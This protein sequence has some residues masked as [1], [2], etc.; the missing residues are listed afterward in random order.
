MLKRNQTTIT[1]YIE[2]GIIMLFSLY[3]ILPSANNSINFMLMLMFVAVYIAYIFFKNFESAKVILM[4]VA[5]IA[6]LALMK[7]LL[8]DT[9][10]ITGNVKI[11]Q[12]FSMLHQYIFMFIP[13]FLFWRVKNTANY[14]QKKFILLFVSAIIAYV[15]FQTMQ[16]VTINPNAMRNWA[17]FEE[18]AKENVANYYFVYAIPIIIVAITTVFRKLNII[19]KILAI[20]A[21]LILMNFLLKA[22]YTLALLIVVIGIILQLFFSIKNV[23][24]KMLFVF[25]TVL[26]IFFL[27]SLLLFISEN[28][29]SEQVSLRL[30]E[31]Y[32][33]LSSGDASGYNL[34]GR[35]ILYEK[36]IIAFFRSPIWGN[37]YLGFDGHATFLSVLSDMGLLGGI[38][39]FYLVISAYNKAKNF[40][41]E[42]A[43]R[44]FYAFFC[45]L[46]MGL[47]NPI[48][49]SLPIA[50]AMWFIAPLA[51][52]VFYNNKGDT[53]R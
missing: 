11:K 51:I 2:I 34:N 37:R 21:I 26:S 47:T 13:L 19:L 12:F 41:G 17:E 44:L 20:A 22:Q 29:E 42:N 52:E 39:F 3:C 15:I 4:F 31:L 7:T 27:P 43:K 16:E 9:Q 24:F 35:L 38:P 25:V 8:T 48:H 45:W 14:R 10:T 49:R 32:V 28:I 33:F 53:T 23:L 46:L 36:S 40:L 18:L 5:V 30:Y 1:S 50:F 6:I